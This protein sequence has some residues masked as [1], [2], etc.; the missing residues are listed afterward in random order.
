MLGCVVNHS[1]GVGGANTYAF[2][3]FSFQEHYTMYSVFIAMYN[4]YKYNV[5]C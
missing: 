4:V 1:S 3:L 5:Q 2:S